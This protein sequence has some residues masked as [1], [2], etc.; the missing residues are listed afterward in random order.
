[1]TSQMRKQSRPNQ[2]IREFAKNSGVLQWQIAEK[3][4]ITE[5]TFTRWMRH[6][7]SDDAKATIIQAIKDI[8]KD[9]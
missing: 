2:D 4:G 5:F 6:E 1:M 9:K 3:I 7:L 8:S